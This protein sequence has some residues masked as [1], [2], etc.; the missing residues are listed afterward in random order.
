[1]YTRRVDSLHLGF[2]LS[3][4]RHSYV[5][6]VFNFTH[7]S[8]E[9]HRSTYEPVVSPSPSF[10]LTHTRRW[11]GPRNATSPT[12]SPVRLSL[13]FR[14]DL[15]FQNG[16]KHWGHYL[17]FASSFH[18]KQRTLTY[19]NDVDRSLNEDV[20]D[21]I[22]KNHTDYNNNPPSGNWP[23]FLKVQE[24]N[25][26]SPVPLPPN[27]SVSRWGIVIQLSPVNGT[28]LTIRIHSCYQGLDGI[29]P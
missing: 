18:I 23:L 27:R 28:T 22:R 2:S 4:H 17:A 26:R 14:L 15:S 19:P 25:W 7:T 5:G 24:F 9:V 11:I 13:L 6:F 8:T 16:Q 20:V 21:K 29:W 12:A 3:S 1:V 10:S